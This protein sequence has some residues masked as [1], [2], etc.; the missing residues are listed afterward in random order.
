MLN[1]QIDIP[2]GVA[3]TTPKPIPDDPEDE[4]FRQG[5]PGSGFSP[6]D[7][8]NPGPPSPGTL[9]ETC[10]IGSQMEPF[11][12]GSDIDPFSQYPRYEQS[13][14][15]SPQS[16]YTQY[17]TTSEGSSSPATLIEPP[18]LFLSGPG[19]L[20]DGGRT[21]QTGPTSNPESGEYLEDPV[22]VTGLLSV[23]LRYLDKDSLRHAEE[24]QRLALE[25]L[26]EKNGETHPDTLV[27]MQNLALICRDQ[28]RY[29]EADQIFSR[30]ITLSSGVCQ[31][32][33]HWMKPKHGIGVVYIHQGRW[34]EAEAAISH[35]TEASKYYLGDDHPDTLSAV[36]SLT[37]V[38]MEMGK[39]KEAEN[40]LAGEG[41]VFE[42]RK[43]RSGSSH[44]ET[45]ATMRTLATAY[46][47]QGHLRRAE[48]MLE[49]VLNMSERTLGGK[50]RQTITSRHCLGVAYL[51]LKKW[52]EAEETLTT[53]VDLS[54]KY[55]GDNHR[56][57][58]TA[59]HNLGVTYL[60]QG[61]LGLAEKQF[62]EVVD[63]SSRHNGENHPDTLSSKNKLA[64][65]YLQL[66]RWDDAQAVSE[67]VVGKSRK[68]LSET[69]P[70]VYQYSALLVSINQERDRAF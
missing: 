23:S 17:A 46:L 1:I 42:V 21:F 25:R 60:D 58:L 7:G 22:V 45:L 6:L 30:N 56:H 12:V 44:P 19:F 37:T 59:M 61:K 34:K 55:L 39:F 35:V 51:D 2:E 16:G 53:V 54:K 15:G 14:S 70:D 57:T 67:E 68:V 63:L 10:T 65:T 48:R 18:R 62:V 38:Y 36:H 28:G 64:K 41:G 31:Y 4:D 43:S 69:H 8:G 13:F 40:L 47:N 29:R 50:H 24:L 27:S 5:A 9:S 11:D 26:K 33:P 3:Y 20:G 49:I 52:K 32:H 66:Q